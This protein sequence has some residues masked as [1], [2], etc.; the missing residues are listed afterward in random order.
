[1][2]TVDE[3]ARPRANC[4]LRRPSAPPADFL[5]IMR[6]GVETAIRPV[7]LSF[8]CIAAELKPAFVFG[9][10]AWSPGTSSSGPHQARIDT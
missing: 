1:M 10:A 3:S 7:P 8:Y 4:A 5:V 9:F 2:S 6:F